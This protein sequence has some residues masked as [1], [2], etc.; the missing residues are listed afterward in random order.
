[1]AGPVRSIELSNPDGARVLVDGRP[2]EQA[3]GGGHTVVI[4]SADVPGESTYTIETDGD[5]EQ[6]DGTLHGMQVTA[7]S[8]DLVGDGVARGFVGG[9]RDGFRVNGEITSIDLANP[10]GATVYV[11][12]EPR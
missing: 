11:D 9:G 12:G 5:I 1:V 6:V 2:Y 3:A 4:D 8:N 10:D 7:Q